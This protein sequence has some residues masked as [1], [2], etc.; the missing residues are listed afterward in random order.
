M[1]AIDEILAEVEGTETYTP[2]DT[3]RLIASLVR[4][5]SSAESESD[6]LD[7]LGEAQAIAERVGAWAESESEAVDLPVS[8]A[9]SAKGH[10]EDAPMGRGDIASTI[11]AIAKAHGWIP[12]ETTEKSDEKPEPVSESWPVD[13]A[14]ET[15]RDDWGPDPDWA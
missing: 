2:E 12:R 7:C 6:A 8:L 5:A 4:K 9:K 10:A 3:L 1:D 14:S 15:T 13:L 11:R